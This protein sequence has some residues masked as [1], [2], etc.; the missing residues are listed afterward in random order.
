[1]AES[2]TADERLATLARFIRNQVGLADR[3]PPGCIQLNNEEALLCAQALERSVET[4]VRRD[5]RGFPLSSHG[6]PIEAVCAACR[7]PMTSFGEDSFIHDCDC[8]YS[9]PSAAGL[10]TA[11]SFSEDS[12]PATVGAVSHAETPARQP[13]GYAYRYP[14]IFGGTEIRMGTTGNQVNG[15]YPIEAIPY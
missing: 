3:P 4:S 10:R 12:E 15:R 6:V 9:A 5:A 1:V 13:D 7:V 8:F 14:S 2:L 11:A